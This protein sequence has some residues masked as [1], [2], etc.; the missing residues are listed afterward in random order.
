[1]VTGKTIGAI[2][3]QQWLRE[4]PSAFNP[5]SCIYIKTNYILLY[6]GMLIAQLSDF[7]N[8]RDYL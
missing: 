4:M 2:F 8:V 7:C 1:M 3:T 6:V 5:P